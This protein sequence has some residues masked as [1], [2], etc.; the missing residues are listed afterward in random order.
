MNLKWSKYKIKKLID[1]GQNL[2]YSYLTNYYIKNLFKYPN[3]CPKM[4]K[5]Y[6]IKMIQIKK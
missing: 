3:F 2:P 5:V 1:L 4:T 6:E